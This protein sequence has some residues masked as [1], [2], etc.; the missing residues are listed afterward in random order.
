[1]CL[2]Q[3]TVWYL[4]GSTTV[5]TDVVLSTCFYGGEY[6][7]VTGLVAGNTY[8]FS[9]CGDTDFD[10]QITVYE[11]GPGAVLGYND[12]GCG[13]QSTIDFVYAG[14]TGN[15]DVLIDQYPCTSNTLCMTLNAQL[16]ALGTPPPPA[17]GC[18]ASGS[19]C[20]GDSNTGTDF[21]STTPPAGQAVSITLGGSIEACCDAIYVRQ[22]GVNIA[23]AGTLTA[24]Y[25][26]SWSHNKPI[27]YLRWLCFLRLWFRSYFFNCLY[28]TCYSTSCWWLWCIWLLL[29]WR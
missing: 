24:I 11:S 18:G 6:A 7:Y 12:D 5:G 27:S 8:R 28:N 1:M 23:F 3:Y 9:T 21:A 2:R 19:Y 13:A 4:L 17:G 16:V 22:N 14:G 15:V 20:Y 25:R 29:L 26:C 10:T